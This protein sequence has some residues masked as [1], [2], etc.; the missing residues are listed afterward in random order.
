MAQGKLVVEGATVQCNQGTTPTS[1]VT[2][3]HTNDSRYTVNGK[4]LMTWLEDDIQHF[5]FGS[6]R[7]KNNAACSPNVKWSDYYQ[8]ADFHGV[9]PLLE[10][11]RG[12][13]SVGGGTITITNHGQRGTPSNTIAA[14][15]NRDTY[16]IVMVTN[17]P[18]ANQGQNC[19][20]QSIQL[21]TPTPASAKSTV[22]VEFGKR[23]M[24]N[25]T[26]RVSSG[27]NAS[28]V[29]WVIFH[30]KGTTDRNRTWVHKGPVFNL[31]ADSLPKGEYRVEAY[32][33][34]PGDQNCS[35]YLNVTEN[36]LEKIIA[37]PNTA[38]GLTKRTPYQFTA[39]YN[40]AT[41]N[42]NN[43]FGNMFGLGGSSLGN[44]S[45]EISQGNNILYNTN[46]ISSNSVQATKTASNQISVIF[47]NDGN[48]K[49]KAF[50]K[51]TAR[52]PA[53][54]QVKEMAITVR[55]RS[56][57]TI[58]KESGTQDM[59]RINQ[60]IHLKAGNI[61]YDY[62]GPSTQGKAYWY[63]KNNGVVKL[64]KIGTTDSFKDLST[65]AQSLAQ[66][67]N[68]SNLYQTYQFEAYGEL[69]TNTNLPFQGPDSATI[70]FTKNQLA[71]IQGP[72]KVPLGSKI[73]YTIKSKMPL[74]TGESVVCQFT[75]P[76]G[77][78]EIPVTGDS[79]QLEFKEKGKY[80]LN[81]YLRGGDVDPKSLDEDLEI[82]AEETVLEEALWCFASGKKRT[83]SSWEEDNYCS[84][85]LKGLAKQ[86]LEF[87]VWA[88]KEGVSMEET[89]AD[90]EKYQLAQLSATT[91]DEGVAQV[92]F[93]TDETAKAKIDPLL[94]SPDATIK[95][96]FTVVLSGTDGNN[97]SG[98]QI[99]KLNGG[100][101]N[102]MEVSQKNH[103]LVLE[104]NDYLKVPSDAKLNG[105]EFTNEAGNEVQYN[106]T[107][108]TKNHKIQV[109]TI[110]MVKDKLIVK[111]Y[112]KLSSLEMEESYNAEEK[113]FAIAKE[114]KSFPAEEVGQDST[115]QLDF[116]VEETWKEEAPELPQKHFFVT[117]FKEQKK[118]DDT[119]ELIQL[120][121]QHEKVLSAIH[122]I[123]WKDDKT[124]L[125]IGMPALEEGQTPNGSQLQSEANKTWQTQRHLVVLPTDLE[126][127]EEGNQIVEVR[128]ENVME[129][130]GCVCKE[131]GLIWGSKISCEERKKVVQVCANLWGEAQK[132]EKANELM[133][134]MNVET[135]GK[136]SPSLENGKGYV[137]L[138]Q[139]SRATAQSLGTTYEKLR[140]MTF[141]EQMDYVEKYLRV[142]QD[143]FKTMTHL[144]MQVIKPNA[145]DHADDPNYVV[146]DESISVPDGDGSGTPKEQREKNITRE[147]WVTKYGYA[148]NPSYMK[149]EGEYKKRRK[150]VYTRQKYED[151]YGFIDGKTY[152]WEFTKHLEESYEQGKGFRTIGSCEN[153][154]NLN[155]SSGF[156]PP[157]IEI[158]INEE[159]KGIRESTNCQYIKD[160]YHGSTDN[161][162][163]NRCGSEND[164][165][166]VNS[167]WCASFVN[168]CLE[169]S[170]HLSQ[171]DPG[172]RWYKDI[173]RV[174]RNKTGV[175]HTTD[176]WAKKYNELYIGG[177]VV[178]ANNGHT[179]FLMGIDKNNTNNYIYLGGNQDNGVRFWTAP[180]SKI[181]N[182]CLIP[183]NFIG[184][185]EP[186][187]NVESKD[188]GKDVIFYKEGSTS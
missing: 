32:G 156:W 16:D 180:K 134:V 173:N 119:T 101:V 39:Q 79:I 111:V 4:K 86:S 85:T 93:T 77:M 90:I 52:G 29:N 45:W 2:V 19:S 177:I 138:V 78:Q 188:F 144:Y 10:C 116:T 87:H 27:S 83:E 5:N 129:Q 65:N 63:V 26:A 143:R 113:L 151:R 20:V 89:L 170:G 105:I 43:L 41:Q 185:L 125:R 94:S 68:Q 127:V 115:L 122:N 168:F 70:Q 33:R 3:K 47:Q 12:T 121:S 137:G 82:N 160:N 112:R 141:I 140:D 183:D 187:K 53:L 37:T 117:V 30:G 81:G 8:N 71:S 157:W 1:P 146:F 74:I 88:L 21:L 155:F 154:S 50:D 149:E 162:K 54:P 44:V 13:C 61:Q 40:F 11:S 118:E 174:K 132:I 60:N 22:N 128:G 136:F 96:L 164:A 80:N 139:F 142:N 48:Y 182:F 72:S 165:T 99:Q 84:V 133:A 25:F 171:Q 95:I 103:V 114:I 64:Y 38:N 110:G 28:L 130:A 91:S 123:V 126:E 36:K 31:H 14:N 135:G 92:K 62:Y 184:D 158:A 24:L 102:S 107:S 67:F 150:W 42:N 153:V 166:R 57:N 100:T 46:G 97:L 69:K 98:I 124:E 175:Y 76:S 179:A 55:A 49:I 106:P 108:Y 120:K 169:S 6:C 176:I 73:T 145:V 148:S 104:P 17:T 186:I 34:S 167:A 181:Y 58:S 66:L 172:A 9:N 15:V 35:I 7:P 178:W 152:V 56:I 147:P 159:A 18:V 131:Y 51:A 161:V 59:M 163:M 75:T 23:Q 109:H